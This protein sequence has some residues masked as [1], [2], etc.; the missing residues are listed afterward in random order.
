M[1][2]LILLKCGEIA[3]KGLNRHTFEAVMIKNMRRRL[4]DLGEFKIWNSQSTIYV[5]PMEEDIDIPLA[6]ERLQTVFGIVA[7]CRA[8]IVEKDFEDIQRVAVEYLEPHLRSARTFKVNAKRS[9]K[10]FPM[11]S[12]EI[13]RE[14]GATLLRRF[15]HLRVNVENPQV[16]VTVEVPAASAAFCGGGRPGGKALDKDA[17]NLLAERALDE[18]GNHILRLAYSYLHNMSDA[19]EVLQDT[20][21][22]LLKSAPYFA[23]KSH[24]KAWLLRVASNLSKNRIAYNKIRGADELNEALTAD[25][26][27]DLSFVWEAVKSL[28]RQELADYL[29]V[30][31]SAMSAELSKLR[32]DG[33]LKFHKNQFDLL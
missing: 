30:E 23:S 13:C 31:R 24:E 22:Q 18:Y 1:K 4:E 3:L 6:L 9:D 11:G 8:A 21:I 20:L 5:Q 19:E 28:P 25:E 33:V 29:S 14:L 16:T 26:G 12:P 15:P 32:D 17:A 27:E 7:L 2:E 10:R